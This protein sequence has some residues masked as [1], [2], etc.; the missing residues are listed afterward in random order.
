MRY[1]IVDVFTDRPFTGN[2]LCVVL[3]PCPEQFMQPIAR[4]VNLSET[5]F[6]EITGDGA[7]RMRIFTPHDELPFAGHP[8]VGTAWALG[9][10]R[11]EQTTSGAVVTIEADR[12]GAV[13]GQPDPELTEVDA[14]GVADALGVPGVEG[15]WR[16]V[17]GGT[18]H[19]LVPTD[20]PLDQ[21]D[22]DVS[23]VAAIT[24]R[25]ETATL[26]PV[27]RLDDRTLQVRAFGP[28]TGIPEDPG[29][30]SAAGPI[31]LLARERWGTDVDV[32]IRQGVEMG[33]PCTIEV[34]A[35]RGNVRV[36]G[37]VTASA[38]GRFLLPG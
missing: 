36:G 19:L 31:G 23:A 3:D 4:E 24:V 11:W 8:S 35:E 6:P 37:R 21:L 15:A 1:R 7:Y 2:G 26:C 34:H 27:R 28:A 32:T 25:L 5:T 9:P 17:T 13:M 38:E 10:G 33:R 29:T 22:L 16:S 12:D 30:G 18:P 20:T 14:T